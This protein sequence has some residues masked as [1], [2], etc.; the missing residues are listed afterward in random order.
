MFTSFKYF[1]RIPKKEKV[2]IAIRE[3]PASFLDAEYLSPTKA[4]LKCS[5]FDN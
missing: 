4:F 3:Y 5:L 2:R 1:I